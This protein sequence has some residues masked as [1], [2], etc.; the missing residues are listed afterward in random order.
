MELAVLYRMARFIGACI[1]YSRGQYSV[2][3]NVEEA[4]QHAWRLW[5]LTE[6]QP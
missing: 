1:I 3:N 6:R 2:V 4:A 5:Q